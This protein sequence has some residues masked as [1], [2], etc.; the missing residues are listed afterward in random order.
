MSGQVV[1][2]MFI[3]GART[4][5]ALG[6]GRFKSHNG[7]RMDRRLRL[8]PNSCYSNTEIVASAWLFMRQVVPFIAV[9]GER[10]DAWPA[11]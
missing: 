1:G 8:K 5:K 4:Y 7:E 10:T 9:T 6:S 11:R 2:V 3:E